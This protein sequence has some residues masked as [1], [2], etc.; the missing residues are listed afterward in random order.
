M[1]ACAGLS[2]SQLRRAPLS[3]WAMDINPDQI[4]ST[5]RLTQD[6]RAVRGLEWL[7]RHT[8]ERAHTVITLDPF[9][10]ERL[11]A[12][13]AIDDK[14][15]VLPPWPLFAMGTHDPLAGQRF[16]AAHGFADKRIVMYSGNLS[17]VHPVDTLLRAATAL[18]DDPR[19]AFVFVGGGLERDAIVRYTREHALS[20]V[21]LLPYQPLAGLPES[22]AA[23]DLHLVAMGEAM[24]GIVHPSKIYSAMA[25]GRPIFAL[26]P[27][28]SHIAELVHDH[29]LGW[30]VE[31]GDVAG[32]LLALRNFADSAPAELAAL[33]E[34]ARNVVHEHYGQAE[35]LDQF[36]ALLE[37]TRL[38][39]RAKT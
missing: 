39:S 11:R 22:L 18:R 20:N 25:A 12:K 16:R 1:A 15:H 10:A 35:R 19:L 38:E 2:V 36:C 9:M 21:R 37:R 33:G 30:H 14:L 31:H 3:F 13:A 27:R 4:L 8:L 6:A 24:V 7:N 5:G 32:A 29:A 17:P 34:R 28:R 26:G 23:A